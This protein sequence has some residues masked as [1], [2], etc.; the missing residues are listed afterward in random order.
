MPPNPTET[1]YQEIHDSLED[2]CFSKKKFLPEKAFGDLLTSDRIK[3][4]LSYTRPLSK[5]LQ[6]KTLIEY[7]EEHA[8]RV[9]AILVY[10]RLVD[11]AFTLKKHGF[12][13]KYLPI[14]MGPGKATTFHLLADDAALKWFENW[15]ASEIASFQNAQW[16]FLAPVF[17]EQSV[18]EQPDDTCPLPFISYDTT[19]D[20]GS[21]GRIHKARIHSSHIKGFQLDKDSTVAIKELHAVSISDRAYELEMDALEL[22]RCL[23]HDHLVKFISGFETYRKHYLM[24]QWVGGGNLRNF[25]ETHSWQ[26]SEHL[27]SWALEQMRGV[28]MGLEKLHGF[29]SQ[30]NCRHGDLKPE[31]IL[32]SERSGEYGVLQIADMG[33]AKIHSVPTSLRQVGTTSLAGTIRYQPPEVQT[34]ISGKR[35]RA[36]DIWSMGCILLELTIWLLHGPNGLNEFNESFDNMTQPFFRVDQEH[37][38]LQANVNKWIEHLRE[39]CLGDSEDRCVSRALRDL[40]GFINDQILIENDGVENDMESNDTKRQNTSDPGTLDIVITRATTRRKNGSQQRR[41]NISDVAATLTNIRANVEVNYLYNEEAATTEASKSILKS[42]ELKE[43]LKNEQKLKPNWPNHRLAR[44]QQQIAGPELSDTWEFCNDNIFARDLFRT[45]TSTAMKDDFLKNPETQNSPPLCDNCGNIFRDGFSFTLGNSTQRC[46]LCQVL[47]PYLNDYIQTLDEKARRNAQI[48]RIGSSLA[49]TSTAT[50]ILSIVV[51]PGFSNIPSHIQRG[52]PYLVKS[53]STTQ[54]QLFKHWLDDC[55]KRH[56]NTCKPDFVQKRPTRLVYV[57]ASSKELKLLD[58]DTSGRDSEDDRYIALSHRWG[59]PTNTLFC[60]T[61]NIESLKRSINY[62]DLP[63]NFQDAVTVTRGL[64][65]KYLWID[66]LCI[67]QGDGGDF[68]TE[69]RLMEDYYSG[70]YCTISASSADE[71]TSGFLD[72]LSTTRDTVRQCHVLQ[73]HQGSSSSESTFYVCNNIDNF[74]RDVEE[75]PLSKRGWV[76]QERALSRRTIHFTKTQVYWEC[77]FGVRCETMSRLFNRRS[78][79]LSDPDFPRSAKQYYRGMRIEFFQYIYSKYSNL[80]FSYE[81]DRSVAMFGLERRLARVYGVQARYGIL[82]KTFLHRS[83]LWRIADT[84]RPLRKIDYKNSHRVPSWSWMAVMGPIKYMDAPFELMD[85]DVDIKSPFEDPSPE[86]DPQL[87]PNY[88]V[89]ARDVLQEVDPRSLIYDRPEYKNLHEGNDPVQSKLKCV[90]VGREKRESEEAPQDLYVLLII[91]T[92]ISKHDCTD[93]ERIGVARIT[94][95][96]IDLEGKVTNVRIV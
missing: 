56:E 20:A 43:E 14:Q 18:L 44:P 86:K 92:D 96:D 76:F 63:K 58:S 73:S 64:G 5:I 25:W 77:G 82:D 88:M 54:E 13:D 93:Y 33:S 65:I 51:G 61:S 94:G 46:G 36:Y 30:R 47:S 66:S 79:F 45:L 2:C 1:L 57:G 84:G 9:F 80:S 74:A 59:D 27:I 42:L 83:L 22:A 17:T 39:T 60:T 12:M 87:V 62:Y 75:S 24:F 81:T 23:N 72:S 35:S 70:A 8:T 10:S 26:R 50:A 67:I 95:D 31:N 52:F 40:L 15:K 4:I 29:N 69:S 34:T 7:I 32:V 21:F 90:I 38:L 89:P 68:D 49:T 28:S 41:A 3:R 71:S 11:K 48:V 78:S 37:N 91:P 85:W 55:D 16:L 53:R 6:S 19:Q